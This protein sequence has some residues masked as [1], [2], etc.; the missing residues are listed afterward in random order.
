MEQLSIALIPSG[1]K[2]NKVYSVLP[3][4]GS[5]D[6]DLARTTTATRINS[7]GLIE[8]VGIG[9]PRLDY[10]D[11]TC[12][13]LLLEPS[14]T[15]LI[16]Y[17]EDFSDS[18]WSRTADT[19]VSLSNVLA[20]NGIDFA[21]KVSASA[22][23]A[24]LY[25]V[26]YN[27]TDRLTDARS[28]YAR[29]VS[30]TGQVRL[31]S[32]N[33]NTNNLFT[34]TEEWQRFEVNSVISTAANNFYA[35][36]FRNGGT[37]TEVLIWGAQ[38]EEQ[39]YATSYIP[40]TTGT[41][42]TR[43]AETASKTGISSLINSSEGGFYTNIKMPLSIVQNHWLTISDGTNQ[44]SIGIV[45]ESNGKTTTRVDVGG[46]IQFNETHIS[47]YSIYQKVAISWKLNE[48]KMFVNGVQIGA[49]DTS[50]LVPS[51]GS[52]S[53][54]QFAYSTNA[55]NFTFSECKDLRV[56]KTALTDSELTTLT[57]L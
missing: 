9:V 15:N 1:Y 52:L 27:P 28:I 43:T 37:L 13:S 4:D 30:G 20:P 42:Q 49:T 36:D 17:S 16:T 45:F 51:V 24:A 38:A 41:V 14:S 39:S 50:G 57:T 29:T 7:E 47:D 55:S 48:F 21:Y 54:F 40:T 10:T 31:C 6:L 2:E 32:F 34:L 56:F 11:G 19:S 22:A 5:G 23:S 33:Q 53:Q 12:P 25:R 46:A 26:S 44:N 3:E 8:D 18:Y 35:V